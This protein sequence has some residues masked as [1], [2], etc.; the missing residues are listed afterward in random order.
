MGVLWRG[1]P[2]PP[3][4]G[5]LGE[6]KLSIEYGQPPKASCKSS[7]TMVY[8]RVPVVS[9]RRRNVTQTPHIA[10]MWRCYVQGRAQIACL[11]LAVD[12]IRL[13]T[14]RGSGFTMRN[15][16]ILWCE[17]WG[18]PPPP[19]KTPMV[20]ISPLSRFSDKG[21]HNEAC[22]GF[23]SEP[24]TLRRPPQS[25][26]SPAQRSCDSFHPRT[27]R[28]NNFRVRRGRG[29][30]RRGGQKVMGCGGRWMV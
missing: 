28:C 2:L 5:L 16:L 11:Q 26:E 24:A 19:P 20:P 8:R 14:R 30:A 9:S 15:R 18:A 12:Q 17:T 21:E 4:H 23:W 13:T 10:C 3:P 27:T 25:H 29:T 22:G 1:G 6:S 7:I